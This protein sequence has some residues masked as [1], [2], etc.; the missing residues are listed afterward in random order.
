[1]VAKE[2]R[3]TDD[4]QQYQTQHGTIVEQVRGG[5]VVLMSLHGMRPLRNYPA[6]NESASSN[7]VPS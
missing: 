5:D 7:M 3:Q 6:H 2:R 4:N 1:M